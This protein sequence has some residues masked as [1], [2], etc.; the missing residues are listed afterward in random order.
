MILKL[1][2]QKNEVELEKNLL[3][4]ILEGAQ[5]SDLSPDAIERFTIDNCKNIY[6]A[7]YET[8]AT[9]ATWCLMLLASNQEW[10]NRVR[11]EV[12]EICKGQVPDSDSIRQMKQV[13]RPLI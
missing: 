5:S 2:K 12:L 4:M 3:Q 7:G 11:A 6:L 8:T 13:Y 1:I 9:A 10:Q